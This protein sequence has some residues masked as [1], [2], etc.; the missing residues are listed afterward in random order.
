M[1]RLL[2]ILIFTL[3]LQS[4]TK[5]DDVRDFKIEGMSVGDILLDY[6]SL[7]EINKAKEAEGHFEGEKTYYF[8]SNLSL[9]ERVRIYTLDINDKI[10]SITGEKFVNYKKC[11]NLQK[12]II[13]EFNNLFDLSSVTIGELDDF[14]T[15]NDPTG[16]SFYTD[17]SIFFK[18][19]DVTYVRCYSYTEES[20][21]EDRLEVAV[22]LKVHDDIMEKSNSVSKK[23]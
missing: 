5:A 16:Q 11:L 21:I 3:S 13:I 7:I 15:V 10:V 9:Y 14:T 12:Q 20:N 2:L 18:N 22:Y 23:K 19:N 17:Y 8:E 6:Y 4:W 1:K